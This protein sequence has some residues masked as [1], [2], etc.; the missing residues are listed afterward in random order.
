MAAGAAVVGTA[1]VGAAVVDGAVV[2]TAVVDGAV[3]G[4]AVVDGAV[5]GA[6]VV[7]FAVAEELLDEPRVDFGAIRL[8]SSG[9]DG[10]GGGSTA[11]MVL[12]PETSSTKG[13]D[14][15]I[16]PQADANSVV[17]RAKVANLAI[18]GRTILGRL[19]LGVRCSGSLRNGW[20]NT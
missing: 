12:P 15:G 19:N 18:W 11:G 1:V 20:S 9:S 4:T 6:L 3:V 14:S 16:A 2:G 8:G 10:E 7:G 17:V 13:K 5:V